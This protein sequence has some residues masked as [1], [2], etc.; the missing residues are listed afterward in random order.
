MVSIPTAKLRGR[1]PF[2][3]ERENLGRQ[4]P[5]GA[6]YREAQGRTGSY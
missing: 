6:E 2:G 1:W 5:S 4:K 3:G